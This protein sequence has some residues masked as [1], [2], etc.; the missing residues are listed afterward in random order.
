MEILNQ[1]KRDFDEYLKDYLDEL[2]EK[3]EQLYGAVRYAMEAPAK[4]LRPM[5]ILLGYYLFKD[6]YEQ[7]LPM[8]L[9]VEIFHNFTLVHDDIMDDAHIR[10]INLKIRNIFPILKNL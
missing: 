1:F 2:P 4:R 5:A 6:D 8:A 7:A 3:P 10:Q 9:S